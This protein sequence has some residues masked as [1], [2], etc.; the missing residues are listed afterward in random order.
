MDSRFRRKDELGQIPL[1][2]KTLQS[3]YCL[4]SGC[5]RESPSMR[6]DPPAAAGGSHVGYWTVELT[7]YSE[8]HMLLIRTLGSRRGSHSS[9]SFTA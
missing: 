8:N 9:F 3:S 1:R 5:C 6:E 4:A 7:V 2:G